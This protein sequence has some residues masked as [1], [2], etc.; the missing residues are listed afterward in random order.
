MVR[1]PADPAATGRSGEGLLRRDD[2][3]VQGLAGA[4]TLPMVGVTSLAVATGALVYARYREIP[5][6]QRLI[7]PWFFP[8][9]SPD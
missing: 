4:I 6:F 5:R 2:P 7:K 9:I 1:I 8:V 3:H